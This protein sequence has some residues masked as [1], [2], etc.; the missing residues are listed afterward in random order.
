MNSPISKIEATSAGGIA[1]V[2][3]FRSVGAKI[4]YGFVAV[5]TL[6]AIVSG[7]GFLSFIEVDHSLTKFTTHNRQAIL[8]RDI[9]AG[10]R[11]YRTQVRE[12]L[13][14][15]LPG[16][17]QEATKRG[18][19]FASLLDRAATE[20]RDAA[21][22]NDIAGIRENYT[23]YAKLF[24]QA[25]ELKKTRDS[26]VSGVIDPQGQSISEI[27][28]RLNVY[29]K[30]TEAPMLRDLALRGLTNSF[31]VRIGT[32][33]LLVR[34]DAGLAE[35]VDHQLEI[36]KTAISTLSAIADSDATKKSAVDLQAA[37]DLYVGSMR[38]TLDVARDLDK[39]LSGPMNDRSRSISQ[40]ATTIAGSAEKNALDLETGLIGLVT[41]AR[42]LVG[43]LALGGLVVGFVLAFFIGRGISRPVVAMSAAMARLAAGE[44]DV[45][46]PGAKRSDEIGR[47]AATV[48]VFRN[49]LIEAERLRIEQESLKTA[50]EGERK[51]ELARLADA[52]ERAMGGVVD[53]VADAATR[54][55]HSAQSMSAAAEQASAQSNAVARASEEASQNVQTVA[56]AAEEL[57]AAIGEIK[58]QVDESARVTD[59]ATHDTE[60]TATNVRELAASVQ[61][62]GKV[63]ELIDEIAGQTNLLALNATIEAARA[64]EAGK[65]FAVVAAEVKQLADQTAKATSDIA[66]QIG[67]IQTSTDQSVQSI[68][69]ITGIIENLDGIVALISAAVDQ[70]GGATREI[71]SNVA[72][73]SRG[74]AEVSENIGG[75]SAAS[76]ES[77]R[78]AGEVLAS[79]R[80]LSQQSETLKTELGRFLETIRAA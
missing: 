54:L 77:S 51:A 6:L 46:V 42:T 25:V 27:F 26:N 65:G 64:G 7:I 47:M 20:I 69:G 39:L 60:A 4:T 9:D 19:E 70:Q 40:T 59:K 12:Y 74:T 35:K 67:G 17:D 3:R 29:A 76:A 24:A 71:A 56:A 5:L 13:L 41:E 68:V 44:R 10:F 11:S 36:I 80:D 22:Q 21:A 75:V 43:G 63:V 33:K 31:G 66:S 48:E 62:I 37:F 79:A 53:N 58:R 73:A 1:G 30:L 72:Q 15:D 38:S 34:E 52:F 2:S 32:A 14:A 18:D 45:D 61:R 28:D 78:A 55:E 23:A 57:S 16:A 50:A 8:A 49:N